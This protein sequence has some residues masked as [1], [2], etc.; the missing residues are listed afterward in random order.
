MGHRAFATLQWAPRPSR[1][2]S[3]EPII[4][5]RE[6]SGGVRRE[7]MPIA[8][9]PAIMLP[10]SNG[11]SARD[12]AI[13][14]RRR[15]RHAREVSID[16]QRRRHH[17]TPGGEYATAAA[18]RRRRRAPGEGARS[19]RHESETPQLID[20]HRAFARL[21]LQT[22]QFLTQ[23]RGRALLHLANHRYQQALAGIDRH[24]DIDVIEYGTV[25]RLSIVPGIQGRL[26][27]YAGRDRAQPSPCNRCWCARRADRRRRIR[28]MA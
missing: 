19:S 16:L 20:R 23:L 1:A 12:H 9:G 13:I 28:C 5:V 6:A 22:L 26:G 21:A 10:G 15:Q 8:P 17:R 24:A 18:R 4:V 2:R 14:E 27:G 7:S 25:L 11:F 3:S